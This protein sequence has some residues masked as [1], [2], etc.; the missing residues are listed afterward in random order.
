MSGGLWGCLQSQKQPLK[1]F[2]KK[3]VVLVVLQKLN[4][5][6]VATLLLPKD[7]ITLVARKTKAEGYPIGVTLRLVVGS[8]LAQKCDESL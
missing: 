2:K 8:E 6:T 5:F 3:F 7:T 1:A 4:S